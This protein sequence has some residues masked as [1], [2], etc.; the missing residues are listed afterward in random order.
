MDIDV[1]NALGKDPLTATIPFIFLS[2]MADKA[3]VRK[4]M[5]LGA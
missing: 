4:G 3:D 1:L 2:A 5:D